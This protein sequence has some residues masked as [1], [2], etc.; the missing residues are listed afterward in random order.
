MSQLLVQLA[1]TEFI[2]LHETVNPFVADAMPYYFTYASNLLRTPFLAQ[3]ELDERDSQRWYTRFRCL[4]SSFNCLSVS[5]F[6]QI[7]IITNAVT[8]DFS[9]DGAV[10]NVQ[11]LPN[12]PVAETLA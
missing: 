12:L 5:D 4:T 10:T 2:A 11:P 9:T 3:S 6:R 8:P 7:V 1:A